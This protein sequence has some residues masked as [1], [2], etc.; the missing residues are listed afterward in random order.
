MKKNVKI[1]GAAAAALLAVAP[2][3]ASATPAFAALGDS[4]DASD[5]TNGPIKL[6]S[7]WTSDANVTPTTAVSN[8]TASGS[9]IPQLSLGNASVSNVTVKAD[10]PTQSD[11]ATKFE[12]GVSYKQT[13]TYSITNLQPGKWYSVNGTAYKANDNGI[14]SDIDAT[15]KVTNVHSF[16]ATRVLHCIDTSIVGGP[17]V[18]MS[19]NSYN[20]NQVIA[21][22]DTASTV[23][24]VI[25]AIVKLGLTTHADSND[26][27]GSA[28]NPSA[29]EVIAQLKKAGIEVKGTDADATFTIPDSGFFYTVTAKNSKNGNTATA[30][31]FF[32]GSED[33][34][35][36]YPV[37]SYGDQDIQE[38][39][40]P[41]N[42]M[43]VVEVKQGD[44]SW[45]PYRGFTARQVNNSDSQ[46]LTLTS[47]SVALSNVNVNV[48]GVYSVTLK[49][50]NSDGRSTSLTY[51]VVVTP[52][53]IGATATKT[54]TYVPG[55]SVRTWAIYGNTPS[56]LGT[57]NNV[58]ANAQIQ[59]YP[60]DT[61]TIDGVSYTK[62]VVSG[63]DT[64]KWIQTKYL[65][66]SWK[67]TNTNTS[68]PSS[69]EEAMSGVAVV[70]YKGR[71]GVNLLNAEG[72]YQNQ[73]VK[74]GSAWKVF[75]KKT[76]NGETM[77]RLGTQSQWIPAKYVSVK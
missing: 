17:Y 62:V 66:G 4:G 40:K 19:G 72:K 73:Y 21:S 51:S 77:Y 39:N 37:I 8:Y 30:R 56:I 36:N 43:P 55:Y 70:T 12:A 50:T 25:D 3:A 71:G 46:K 48:P 9:L 18:A 58:A 59:V 49:V 13:A 28:V 76:I 24:E 7:T 23:G 15:G 27:E 42:T 31:V 74:K 52:G 26:V 1:L 67:N 14:L 38:G 45:R 32:K 65:D 53:N 16:T 60:N 34:Q 29:D 69:S 11:N 47:Q 22:V 44:T 33:T 75:A 64:N 10:G 57:E 54:V 5:T 35:N 2:V 61:K 20:N 41:I 6:T 68:K 63:G